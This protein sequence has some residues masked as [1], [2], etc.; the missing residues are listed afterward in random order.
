[1]QAGFWPDCRPSRPNFG[2]GFRAFD[3]TKGLVRYARL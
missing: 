2:R 3:E 1:M